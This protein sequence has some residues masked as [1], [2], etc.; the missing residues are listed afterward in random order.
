MSKRKGAFTITAEELAYVVLEL[1]AG[2][3]LGDVA[4]EM[5]RDRTG[6]W[7]KLNR[8]G[9][10][11]TPPVGP[12]VKRTDVDAVLTQMRG[13]SREQVKARVLHNRGLRRTQIRAVS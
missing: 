9:L 6:L 1:E 11:T 13:L 10:P 2:R 12:T 7:R 5:G 3:I 8:L 4:A